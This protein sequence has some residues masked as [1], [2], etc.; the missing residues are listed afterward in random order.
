MLYI[1]Q[2]LGSGF[3]YTT[4]TNGTYNLAN[5]TFTEL[6]DGDDLPELS[7]T[8]RQATINSH[9][10]DTLTNTTMSCARTLWRFAQVFFNEYVPSLLAPLKRPEPGIDVE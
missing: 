7:L 6:E 10:N 3:S 5:K 4:L 9:L 8:L 2:P 1:D